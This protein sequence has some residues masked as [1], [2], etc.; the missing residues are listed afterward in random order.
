MHFMVVGLPI[1]EAEDD[2]EEGENTYV[3]SSRV[4]R[5]MENDPDYVN[6]SPAYSCPTM[7]CYTVLSRG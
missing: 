6:I 1:R 4:Q 3:N 2:D 7:Y 5:A